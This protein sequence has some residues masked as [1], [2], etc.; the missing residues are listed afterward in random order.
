MYQDTN[1]CHDKRALNDYLDKMLKHWTRIT[2]NVIFI[3]QLV[4]R[5][6]RK[7]AIYCIRY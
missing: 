6:I 2:I 7:G 4:K 3:K 1:A 5:V